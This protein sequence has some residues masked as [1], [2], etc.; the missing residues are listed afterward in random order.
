MGSC[1]R[2]SVTALHAP[3]GLPPAARQSTVP[4]SSNGPTKRMHK[5]SLVMST[6]HMLSQEPVPLHSPL[7][8][9]SEPGLQSIKTTTLGI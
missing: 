3:G 4:K 9:Q 7:A 5:A 8:L 1:A 6:S 2:V